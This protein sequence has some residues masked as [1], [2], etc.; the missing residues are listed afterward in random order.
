M[1]ANNKSGIIRLN[2][3]E[4]EL[5]P[6]QLVEKQR[7]ELRNKIRDKTKQVIRSEEIIA[8]QKNYAKTFN[9]EEESDDEST[10]VANTAVIMPK[11]I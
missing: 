8:Q 7:Q 6:K 5:T 1:F 10:P 11:V 9:L 2:L 4:F 3:E